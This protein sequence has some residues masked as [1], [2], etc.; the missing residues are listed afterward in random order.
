MLIIWFR[1]GR[2]DLLLKQ[3]TKSQEAWDL[4]PAPPLTN[5]EVICP[6]DSL[7]CLCASVSLLTI[8]WMNMLTGGEGLRGLVNI[9]IYKALCDLQMKG[10]NKGLYLSPAFFPGI[11]MCFNEENKFFL[12]PKTRPY[13][14]RKAT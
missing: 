2:V 11:S 14:C 4:I 13:S 7:A 10:L 6:S 8:I 3:E 5:N 12:L 9:N 1:K